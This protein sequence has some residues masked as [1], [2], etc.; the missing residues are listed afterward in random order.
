MT[1][2]QFSRE[3]KYQ[4]AVSIARGMLAQGVI[5]ADDFREILT[6]LAAKYRPFFTAI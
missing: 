4:A 1:R 3:K 2:E 6:I 5:T